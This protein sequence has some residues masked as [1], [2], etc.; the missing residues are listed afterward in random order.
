MLLAV[1]S[2]DELNRPGQIFSSPPEEDGVGMKM[3]LN[4]VKI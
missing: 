1:H 2:L 3:A 4:E